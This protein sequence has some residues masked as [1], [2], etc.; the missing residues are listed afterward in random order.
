VETKINIT[1]KQVVQGAQLMKPIRA[2]DMFCGAGGSST[3]AQNVG[4]E[5]VAGF[6]LWE[7]AVKTYS[8]NF[9]RAKTYSKDIRQLSP[10]DIR[11]EIGNIDLLLA[12]PECTNHSVAKGAKER[13]EESR[14]TA[15]EVVR[16]AKEFHPQWVVLE[17][18]IQM[19]SWSK[20][21]RLLDE[22]WDLG[23]FVNQVKLNAQNFGVPQSRVRLFLLCSLSADV[24]FMRPINSQYKPISSVLDFSDIYPKSRLDKPSRAKATLERAQRAIDVLGPDLPFL[25]VY[26][27]TD[28]GGGW[29]KV[30]RP[31]RTITTLDRFAYVEPTPN[32]HMMR[33]L[34]PEELKLAMGYQT[35]FNL[36][37]PGL[38]R[39]DKIKLMGNGVCPP[40]ME[41]V[42]NQ[43]TR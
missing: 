7:S 10:K 42:V 4:V 13:D 26:Y 38:T 28:G 11:K 32:G 40:V 6:D 21:D 16:F 14:M 37:I 2:I 15:F 18:V 1:G 36:N 8:A 25:L 3:G 34:Q 24:N 31:L 33:M 30:D 9:P 12:S 20:H 29:Q 27:G 23:Y 19:R 22:L 39:R 35:D 5:I 41:Y 17:N 43:L